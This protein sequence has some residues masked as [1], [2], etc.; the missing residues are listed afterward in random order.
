MQSKK[1]GQSLVQFELEWLVVQEEEDCAAYI[2]VTRPLDLE[3]VGL[4][5]VCVAPPLHQVVVR[6]VQILVQLN[7]QRL[8][9]RS[10]NLNYSLGG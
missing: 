3:P 2:L 5:G 9:K 10:N 8:E 6:A 1:P 7:D 4:L